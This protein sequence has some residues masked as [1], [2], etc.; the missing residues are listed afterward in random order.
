LSFITNTFL[1]FSQKTKK[2]A[3]AGFLS[4]TKKKKLTFKFLLGFLELLYITTFTRCNTLI[5]HRLTPFKRVF[6]GFKL[7]FNRRT[8][9]LVYFTEYVFKITTVIRRGFID[10]VTMDHDGW[11]ILS[12]HMRITHF[13]TTTLNHRRLVGICCI[14]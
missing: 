9:K 12:A 6:R 10:L 13:N 2:P 3:S 7:D 4:K 5:H 1:Y 14:I 11:W 8:F